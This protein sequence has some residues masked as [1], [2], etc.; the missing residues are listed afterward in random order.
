MCQIKHVIVINTKYKYRDFIEPKSFG[1][2]NIMTKDI[3]KTLELNKET[4][5]GE[6]F[7]TLSALKFSS[8]PWAI[9][10]L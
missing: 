6:S 1:T 4:A 7:F 5:L 10:L 2:W 8:T 3:W 9:Y